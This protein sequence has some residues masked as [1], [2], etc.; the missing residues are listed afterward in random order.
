LTLPLRLLARTRPRA[1]RRT[2]A[3]ARRARGPPRLASYPSVRTCLRSIPNQSAPGFTS[4]ASRQIYSKS[5]V[6]LSSQ[7]WAPTFAALTLRAPPSIRR[8]GPPA[9]SGRP[10]PFHLQ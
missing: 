1:K 4:F 7:P 3:M 6:N 5:P 10:R 9:R 2:M 8:R